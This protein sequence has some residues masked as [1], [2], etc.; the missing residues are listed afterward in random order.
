MKNFIVT[1][2]VNYLYGWFVIFVFA[3]SANLLVTVSNSTAGSLVSKTPLTPLQSGI[4]LLVMFV[5]LI[6][7]LIINV[8][9]FKKSVGNE[10]FCILAVILAFALNPTLI[11]VFKELFQ[12]FNP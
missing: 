10:I 1:F 2:V 11:N 3:L 8:N 12:N 6:L 4:L 9:L 5:M 7:L